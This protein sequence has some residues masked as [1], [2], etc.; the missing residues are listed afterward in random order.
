MPN[1][2]LNRTA[3]RQLLQVPAP[4]RL[5]TTHGFTTWLRQRPSIATTPA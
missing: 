2:S 3:R 5:R 1:H 4:G